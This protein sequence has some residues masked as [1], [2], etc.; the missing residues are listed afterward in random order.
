MC[1]QGSSAPLLHWAPSGIS[2]S[3]WLLSRLLRHRSFLLFLLRLPMLC[4]ST[5]LCYAWSS[6]FVLS[7]K[8]R[9]YPRVPPGLLYI[10]IQAISSTI[11]TSATILKLR[12]PKL[13]FT[14]PRP[15]LTTAYGTYPLEG[16]TDTLNPNN[17][18]LSAPIP[19]FFLFS[20]QQWLYYVHRL[21]WWVEQ[22]PSSQRCPCL[23]P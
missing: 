21:S 17:H 9:C 8:H 5:L 13:I 23:N 7:L 6:S 1:C 14:K 11:T 18:Q 3:C 16:S 20:T 4:I 10:P 19:N 15:T 12:T 2:Q 22:C